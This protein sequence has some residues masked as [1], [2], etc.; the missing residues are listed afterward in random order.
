M[1]A[2]HRS[3]VSLDIRACVLRISRH[4]ALASL[5]SYALHPAAAVH[6]AWHSASDSTSLASGRGTILSYISTA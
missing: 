6:R 1:Q 2:V 3:V 4:V 5:N